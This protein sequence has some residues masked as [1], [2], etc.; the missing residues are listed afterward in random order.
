MQYSNHYLLNL[1]IFIKAFILLALNLNFSFTNKMLSFFFQIIK[2]RFR[3]LFI[4]TAIKKFLLYYNYTR[5]FHLI[6]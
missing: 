3:I 4:L 2:N 6:I 1:A 5:I